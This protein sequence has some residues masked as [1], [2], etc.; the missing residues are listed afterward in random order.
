[1]RFFSSAE[2]ARWCLSHPQHLEEIDVSE[3]R[4]A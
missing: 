2:F 3:A 1:V 4:A